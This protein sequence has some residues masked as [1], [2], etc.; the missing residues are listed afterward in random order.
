MTTSLVSQLSHHVLEPGDETG[1]AGVDA[2]VAGVAARHAEAGQP[3]HLLI[4]CAE[5]RGGQGAATVALGAGQ[6]GYDSSNGK[7]NNYSNNNNNN[8]NS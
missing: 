1:H 3:D 4:V 6:R 5:V 7:S 2:G 8:N